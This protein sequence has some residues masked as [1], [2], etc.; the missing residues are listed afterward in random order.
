MR[1]APQINAQKPEDIL[2]ALVVGIVSGAG[3]VLIAGHGVIW[4]LLLGTVLGGV[5]WAVPSCLAV[6]RVAG[7]GAVRPRVPAETAVVNSALA[8]EGQSK[9]D[10]LGAP[11]SGGADDLKKIK[12]IGPKLEGVLNGLGIHHYDQIAG[13]TAD[14]A[15]WVDANLDG[16]HGRVS[17]DD[18]VAQ[19]RALIAEGLK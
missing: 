7:G 12:G 6:R 2:A 14:Q 19:A 17:R 11:R 4:G 16:F 3:L 15:A 1:I 9:P 5:V 13:W 8:E 10:L 18:W